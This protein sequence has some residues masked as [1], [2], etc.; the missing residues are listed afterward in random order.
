MTI[1]SAITLGV[2]LANPASAQERWS[3]ALEAEGGQL[4]AQAKKVS[5]KAPAGSYAAAEETASREAITR[6]SIAKKFGY[7]VSEQSDVHSHIHL[8]H[9][10]GEPLGYCRLALDRSS[11]IQRT[12][13]SWYPSEGFFSTKQVAYVSTV[14]VLVKH[15]TKAL[16][17]VIRLVATGSATTQDR[18]RIGL[19]QAAKNQHSI[20]KSRLE[21]ALQGTPTCPKTEER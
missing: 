5:Q 1:F 4:T 7:Q 21:E 17:G 8:I 3:Q 15:P 11:E 2:L 20:S 14:D 18:L 16:V 10:S 6:E 13:E 19:D 12:S 9:P